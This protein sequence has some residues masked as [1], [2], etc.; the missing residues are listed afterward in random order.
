[1]SLRRA[2]ACGA[3]TLLLGISLQAGA[4]EGAPVLIRLAVALVT[5][6]LLPGLGW[7]SALGTAPAGGRW[8]AVGWALP[9]GVAWAGL[10]VLAC[11][12]TGVPFTRLIDT[13]GLPAA[14]PWVAAWRLAPRRL[15]PSAPPLD[16]SS[17]AAVAIAVAAVLAGLHAAL[18][19]TP[20]TLNSDSPD[21]IGTIRRMLQTGS[22]FPTDAFFRDAGATGVDPRKGLWHPVVAWICGAA[23]A[24]P[25][26]AWRWLS[27]LLA[28]LFVLNAAA[29]GALLRGPRTAAFAAW[30]L[31]LTYGGS[32]GAPYLREAVF[33]TKLADQFAL[34]VTAAVLM[35]LA[36]PSRRGRLTVAALLL[37]A[38]LTHVF[39]V[40]H[41]GLVFGALTLGL[42]LR[43]RGRSAEAG[44]LVGTGLLALAVVAPYLA[45]RAQG[46]YA[47]SNIIH[48]EPQGLLELG[49]G[50]RTVSPG[51]L[52]DWMG[53]AWLV[54]P[55]SM[56]AW[57]RQAWRTPVL[58]LLTTWT[59]VALVLFFPPL[60]G[61][62]QPRLGYLL[63]RFTWILPLS[64]ALAFALDAAL[65][66][67]RHGPALRRTGGAL[68]LAG[69]S[70]LVRAPIE[71]AVLAFR[72]AH[73]WRE[74]DRPVSAPAW[75]DAMRWM[76][77]HLPDGTVVLA[78]PA[79][80]YLVPMMTRHH[81]ATLLDQHSSPNDPHALERI[82]NAR[83]ALEPY[84][85]WARTREVVR[86]WGITAI[87]LNGRFRESPGLDY[88]SPD[89]AWY[90]AAR[91]RLETQPGVFRRLWERDHFTVYAIDRTALDTL[92]AQAPARPGVRPIDP[93]EA[94]EAREVGEQVSLLRFRIEPR[95]VPAGDTVRARFAWHAEAPRPAGQYDLFLRFERELPPE[96]QGH[97]WFAKPRRKLVEEARGERYRFRVDH[98]PTDGTYGVDA[99]RP[100]E[101]IPDSLDI[102]IPRDVAAGMWQVQARVRRQPHYPNYRLRD[103]FADD[104]YYSGVPV[105]SIRIAG[106]RPEPSGD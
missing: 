20:L 71:D 63:I 10:L 1:M 31:L 61:L 77:Q 32:L 64:L 22:A 11:H 82:L 4:W 44:R 104:D 37:G 43:D 80:S 23:S 15:G 76:D 39:A 83:D 92:T 40:I 102:A 28:P 46:A 85:P 47:P 29:L 81:V 34:A 90:E 99:W 49:G 9:L 33:A 105:D 98:T 38:V 53:L 48:L 35:D 97:P 60:F 69:L 3:I 88:W 8:L 87:A 65:L 12:L 19:G 2:L 75:Q 6:V 62:L 26:P 89:E 14:L 42:W 51:V 56:L 96:A 79:T 74:R 16:A 68:A 25:L 21:H 18:L 55:A 66:A 17:A 100:G 78:D 54:F 93:E 30:A 59:A 7:L 95:E 57:V 106:R 73:E 70:V 50:W 5:L 13:A 41:A 58:L 72:D 84:A 52:W 45:W 67:L 86:R 27:A 36:S 94:R 91:R 101:L 103:Y 24:D